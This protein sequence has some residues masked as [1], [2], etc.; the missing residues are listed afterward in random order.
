M[1]DFN[2][3]I[4]I[5]IGCLF[6]SLN[7]NAQVNSQTQIIFNK[8]CDKLNPDILSKEF[9]LKG[10][11]YLDNSFEEGVVKFTNSD[12]P[13]KTK[14]RYFVFNQEFQL[15]INEDTLA[16]NKSDKI[17]Y[18]KITDS[19]FIY[20]NSHLK[21][22]KSYYEIL[23]EGKISLLKFYQCKLI[24]GKENVSSF[25][26]KIPD[27][28]IIQSKL[29][30]KT[31]KQLISKIPTIKTLIKEVFKD[32]SKELSNFIK[33]NKLKHKKESDLIMIFNYYNSIK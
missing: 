2:C 23:A 21:N 19:K 22:S 17:E 29:F 9:N 18:I 10:E 26:E 4:L 7:L 14:L 20:T 32:K 33:T 12:T 24:K 3:S 6:I 13:S 31:E 1:K 25:E 27:H 5:L 8:Y 15:I 30:Y 16:L 11:Y 28:Y